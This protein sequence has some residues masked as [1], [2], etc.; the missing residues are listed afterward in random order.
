MATSQI[1]CLNNEKY[2]CKER[3]L[4]HNEALLSSYISSF[5]AL[6]FIFKISIK[7]LDGKAHVRYG[8]IAPTVRIKHPISWASLGHVPGFTQ[9]SYRV[10]FLFFLYS[11]MVY[12]AS[13]IS[14][15]SYVICWKQHRHVQ[16]CSWCL[17]C[18]LAVKVMHSSH[19]E[20]SRF[21]SQ[22][23]SERIYTSRCVV[24]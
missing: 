4:R 3:D 7:M 20:T 2:F 8:Q 14:C 13:L 6:T 21:P 11:E 1:N 19:I 18:L 16:L 12:L 10:L 15:V 17:S 5:Q 9:P 23:K 24:C 22:F